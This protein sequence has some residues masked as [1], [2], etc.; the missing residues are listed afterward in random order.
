LHHECT[1]N[2]VRSRANAEEAKR[3]GQQLGDPLIESWA[4][5]ELG[6]ALHFEGD[7]A[8]ASPYL[9]QGAQVW[10]KH[11]RLGEMAGCL[12]H[13]GLNAIALGDYEAALANLEKARRTHRELGTDDQVADD[14]R[15]QA[16]LALLYH[17]LG[18]NQAAQNYARSAIAIDRATGCPHYLASALV[19]L[20]HASAALGQLDAAAATYQEALDLR[21]V[22]GQPH[23]AT[24]PQAGLA[25]VALTQK[26]RAEALAYVDDIL[27]YLATESVDG[28]SEPLR[29]YLTCYRVLQAN[30]DPRADQVLATAHD[31]LQERAAKIDDEE[32]R[33]SYLENVAAHREI[34]AAFRGAFASN[35]AL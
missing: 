30:A 4:G 22:L 29:I 2:F 34:V 10:G 3:L 15:A 27:S 23:L 5:F 31:L 28:T 12:I 33:S 9:K 17:Q 7:Y 35:A 24:E 11:G 20:G 6:V 18:E 25:R 32:W 16:A 19:Q 13:V 1:G 8:S 26:D 21:R 14:A